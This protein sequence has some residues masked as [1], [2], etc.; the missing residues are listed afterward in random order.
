MFTKE[1][2]SARNI[3]DIMAICYA[4]IIEDKNF[5]IN[6]VYDKSTMDIFNKILNKYL[7]DKQFSPCYAF[8]YLK[9]AILISLNYKP[10]STTEYYCLLISIDSCEI[11]NYRNSTYLDDQFKTYKSLNEIYNKKIKIYPVLLSNYREDF[12]SIYKEEYKNNYLRERKKYDSLSVNSKLKSYIIFDDDYNITIHELIEYEDFIN[13][14]YNKKELR[15][16]ICP[17]LNTNLHD[18]FN[19]T[20]TENMKFN[21]NNMKDNIEGKIIERCNQFIENLSDNIDFLIFP[22]MLM[23][24]KIINSIISKLHEQ[25]IK[26]VFCGSVWENRN[27]ICHVFYESMEIF[28]YYKK[29]PFDLKYSEDDFKTIIKNCSNVEQKCLLDSFLFSHDF[30]EKIIFSEHLIHDC[31]IHVIDINNFGRILTYICKDIDDDCYM[32]LTRILQG[33]FIILPA[34]NPSNDLTNNAATLSERYHCT[35][36][37]CNTC[38][39]LKHL[40]ENIDS[41]NEKIENKNKIGFI[42]TPSKDNTTRSHRKI[43]YTFNEECRNCDSFCNGRIFNID[44]EELF[45]ENNIV[46]LNVYEMKRC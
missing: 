26:F 12:N 1:L 34:C 20:Y 43:F 24:E 27:N 46:S 41:L 15:I 42:I 28:Q 33:D 21:I 23:T 44:L 14:I 30:K 29:I 35:T 37:M 19:I 7:E 22:E 32:N 4:H 36:I 17:I 5:D 31:N 39:S 38:S 40:E 25:D 11:Y 13:R 6:N 9:Q 3:Y 18:I 16:A 2:E 8:K 45:F 10:L